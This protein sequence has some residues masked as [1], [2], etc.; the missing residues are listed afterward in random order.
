MQRIRGPVMAFGCFDVLHEGH[1][2]YLREAKKLG[3]NLI[4]VVARDANAGRKL[5]YSEEERRKT[6][7]ELTFV[8]VAVLGDEKKTYAVLK[9]FKPKTIVLGYDQ[10]TSEEKIR[11]NAPNAKI[12]R[13]K[14]FHPEKYK[15]SIIKRGMKNG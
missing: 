5:L 8:D 7:E 2:H 11:E 10:K 13:L 6:I 12:I 3:G 14:A 4:V 9:K 1:K 15:S